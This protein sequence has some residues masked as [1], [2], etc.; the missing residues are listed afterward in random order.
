[1]TTKTIRYVDDVGRIILPNNIRKALNLQKGTALEIELESSGTIRIR[2]ITERCVLCGETV[3][4]KPR[5]EL[6]I[7]PDKKY[8]CC[9]CA[10]AVV[11][12]YTK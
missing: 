4:G 8:V 10:Q 7:G 3:E 1:M 6:T 11:K 9:A 12:N 2:C 5:A